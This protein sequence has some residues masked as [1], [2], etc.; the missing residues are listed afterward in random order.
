MEENGKALYTFMHLHTILILL[1]KRL[2]IQKQLGQ[3]HK[4]PGSSSKITCGP[5]LGR[6]CFPQMC[7]VQHLTEAS[8][9][10]RGALVEDILDRAFISHGASKASS[11]VYFWQHL[12]EGEKRS[13]R[14]N[15][16]K[17]V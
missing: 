13:G 8:T 9:E 17:E 16:T 11:R 15:R 10:T 6:H 7:R 1:E 3:T 14:K 2:Q 4:E 12:W 5:E